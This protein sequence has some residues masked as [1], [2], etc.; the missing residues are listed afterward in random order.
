MYL[1]SL[2]VINHYFF[3]YSINSCVFIQWVCWR[4]SVTIGMKNWIFCTTL[5][6]GAEGMAVWISLLQTWWAPTATCNPAGSS[7]AA[8]AMQEKEGNGFLRVTYF[9]WQGP[10]QSHMHGLQAHSDFLW[11]M[12]GERAKL[13]PGSCD[14]SQHLRNVLWRRHASRQ[15]Y[16]LQ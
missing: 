7:T 9:S 12:W 14:R 4:C 15:M 13:L 2:W 11:G 6:I 10:W 1:C 16:C 8:A 3:F 5:H